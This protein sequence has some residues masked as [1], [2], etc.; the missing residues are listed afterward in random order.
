[1]NAMVKEVEIQDKHATVCKVLRLVCATKESMLL[2]E[3][4]HD[5]Y[6]RI[7]T[8]SLKD[9]KNDIVIPQK[10]MRILYEGVVDLYVRT[11]RS[12]SYSKPNDGEVIN[13]L[14]VLFHVNLS[15]TEALRE[16]SDNVVL[17]I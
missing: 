15:M 11:A 16:G 10:T 4:E 12:A 17:S 13:L 8:T 9:R 5:L 14:R 1:M 7:E 6:N 2:R 3:G